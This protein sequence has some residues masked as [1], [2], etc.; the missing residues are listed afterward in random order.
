MTGLLLDYGMTIQLVAAVDQAGALGKDGTMAWYIPQELRYFKSLTMGGVIIMGRVTFES[1]G[2]PLP[3]RVSIVVS[4]KPAPETHVDA[5][6]VNS[7]EEALNLARK[8]YPERKIWIGG[9]ASIYQQALPL[10]DVVY[11]TQVPLTVD[12]GDVFFPKL[13][14]LWWTLADSQ[15]VMDATDEKVLFTTQRYQRNHV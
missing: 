13:N 7:L 6:W 3:G 4:S 8:C 12:G 1:I 15:D 5:L 9:G 10:A 14:P 11:L 2:R